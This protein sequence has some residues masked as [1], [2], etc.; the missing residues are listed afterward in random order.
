MLPRRPHRPSVLLAL[1]LLVGTAPVAA[2]QPSAPRYQ[3]VTERNVM[4]PMADGTRLAVD[5]YRPDAPGRFL[6]VRTRSNRRLCIRSIAS[7]ALAAVVTR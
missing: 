7:S 1:V 3:V 2:Q 6:S 4:V 5:I